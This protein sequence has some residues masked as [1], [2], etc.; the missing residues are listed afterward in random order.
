MNMIMM[1]I[2]LVA[3]IITGIV[4]LFRE[5]LLV[6][7]FLALW[8]GF[9]FFRHRVRNAQDEKGHPPSHRPRQQ[10]RPARLPSKYD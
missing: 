9:I 7:L 10:H 3:A 8:M 2:C 6:V 5:P 4:L 1:F